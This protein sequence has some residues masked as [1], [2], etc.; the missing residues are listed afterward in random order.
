MVRGICI[1][2]EGDGTWRTFDQVIKMFHKEN[3]QRGP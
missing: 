2:A 1:T 3:E